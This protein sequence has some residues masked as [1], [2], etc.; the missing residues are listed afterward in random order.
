MRAKLL[1]LLQK[2]PVVAPKSVFL[3]YIVDIEGNLS[4]SRVVSSCVFLLFCVAAD[5][6]SRLPLKAAI[7]ASLTRPTPIE[8]LFGF[9]LVFQRRR[10]SAS[11]AT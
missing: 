2:K 5:A 1:S 6:A 7:V 4:I 8:R 10:A 11:P 9:I 3:F